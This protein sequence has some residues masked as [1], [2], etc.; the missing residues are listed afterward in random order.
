MA[1]LSKKLTV[2]EFMANAPPFITFDMGF[3]DAADC[4]GKL[5]TCTLVILNQEKR[6]W[7]IITSSEILRLQEERDVQIDMFW[8]RPLYSFNLRALHHI[9]PQCTI[10]DAYLTERQR[11]VYDIAIREG[12]YDPQRKITLTTLAELLGVS[13]STLSAQ[14]QRV[15]SKVMNFFSD[16]IRRRSP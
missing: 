13:K 7:S 5:G 12:F 10:D 3:L 15:E 6:P 16:E 1:R 2:G 14:L 11:Q 9:G 8:E 4:I